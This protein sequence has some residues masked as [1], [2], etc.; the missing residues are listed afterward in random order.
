[1]TYIIKH[2]RHIDLG[3]YKGF[4]RFDYWREIVSSEFVN[5][6]CDPHE[7]QNVDDFSADLRAGINLGEV[8]ISE[9]ISNPQIVRRT[10]TQISK[11]NEDDFLINVQIKN[12]SLITQADKTH[13]LK[14]GDFVLYD[15]SEPYA[16][17]FS[18]DFH[19]LVIQVPRKMLNRY[20]A[21]P[22]KYLA[23]PVD[24][25][26]GLG[27]IFRE[28]AIS[29][30]KELS[31]NKVLAS[32][33]L[34]ENFVAMMALSLGSNFLN[35]GPCEKAVVKY[36]LIQRIKHY[37]DNNALDPTLDNKKIAQSQG[38]SV[39]YLYKL[40]Q[41][42]TETPREIII[43]KRLSIAHGLLSSAQY[44]KLSIESI[45]DTTG[46]SSASHFSTAFMK[47]YGYRPSSVAG[48]K[49]ES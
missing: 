43:N 31:R 42:E 48:L 24:A 13:V 45:A 47:K 18:H 37:I 27:R 29:L 2:G 39:R 26:G 7:D 12:N 11:L 28:Y 9:I 34:A 36:K 14:Q 30:T 19:Q 44:K 49:D 41:N 38:I 1:M 17:T 5:S 46:F 3:E 35:A 4:E 40:F 20:I 21:S 25:S 33:H 22:E 15:S 16:L 8:K 32:E 6:L 10:P 23:Q